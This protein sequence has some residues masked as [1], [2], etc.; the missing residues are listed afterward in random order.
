MNSETLLSSAKC[1]L[2]EVR[3][4]IHFP[5]PTDSNGATVEQTDLGDGSLK[6]TITC[7][8]DTNNARY[9]IETGTLSDPFSAFTRL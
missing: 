3:S 4:T 7:P 8:A 2:F 1:F 9:Y 6:Q 5:F